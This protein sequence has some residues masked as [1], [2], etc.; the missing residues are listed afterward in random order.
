MKLPRKKV[1]VMIGVFLLL[2]FPAFPVL[3]GVRML[4][5]PREYVCSAS[6]KVRGVTTEEVQRQFRSLKSPGT[7]RGFLFISEL[8]GDDEKGVGV[9]VHAPTPE[10]AAENANVLAAQL[11]QALL[12][13]KAPGSGKAEA[14]S[15]NSTS[16]SRTGVSVV[17]EKAEP[18]QAELSTGLFAVGMAAALGLLFGAAGVVAL[19]MAKAACR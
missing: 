14:P 4:S 10:A 3:E 19:L 12:T 1:L 9:G 5:R 6:L 2:C 7:N 16:Q 8:V 18:L 17:L 15:G 11:Q 13:A